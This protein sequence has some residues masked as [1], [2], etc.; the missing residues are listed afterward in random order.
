MIAG[1]A[2]D[3]ARLALANRSLLVGVNTTKPH[4]H[5]FNKISSLPAC[6]KPDN[7]QCVRSGDATISEI[8]VEVVKPINELVYVRMSEKLLIFGVKHIYGGL[9][10]FDQ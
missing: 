1:R 6:L 8:S 2:K 3:S 5:R 10:G 7:P 4:D 9:A